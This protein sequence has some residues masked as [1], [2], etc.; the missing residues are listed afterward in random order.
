M[1][2]V[3]TGFFLAERF[4]DRD[5]PFHNERLHVLLRNDFEDSSKRV[6]PIENDFILKVVMRD[7]FVFNLSELV[8]NNSL[9]FVERLSSN[10]NEVHQI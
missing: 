7:V 5:E 6:L 4:V 10:K 8:F 1:R 2:K 9:H 3:R